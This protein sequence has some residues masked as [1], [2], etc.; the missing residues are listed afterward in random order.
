MATLCLL[1]R[2][3]ALAAPSSRFLFKANA[4]TRAQYRALTKCGRAIS[5]SWK[6]SAQTR[7]LV[8]FERADYGEYAVAGTT[9][10]R[11]VN[12][13]WHTNAMAK[14]ITGMDH[15]ARE[16]GRQYYDID[17]KFNT[18]HNYYYGTDGKPERWQVDFVTVC[19]HEAFHGLFMGGTSVEL[20][21]SA[22]RVLLGRIRNPVPIRYNQFLACETPYGDCAIASYST[23][24]NKNGSERNFARCVTGNALWFRTAKERIARIQAPNNFWQGASLWHFDESTYTTNN[25]LLTPF[26]LKGEVKHKLDPL[27]RPIMNAMMDPAEPGA[28]V[29]N[30]SV[31]PSFH[32]AV[33]SPIPY[34]T[35]SI[36]PS[37]SPPEFVVIEFNL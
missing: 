37:P 2:G 32:R 33:L 29:C 21:R 16:S 11:N 20:R 23:T 24:S 30:S 5:A 17:M 18:R 1:Q 8:T 28:P 27:L 34:P 7:V 9:A 35:P 25:S 31:Q 26:I 4:L 15:N 22:T 13:T 12:G 3:C 36:S 10:Y 6:S 19:L 14:A